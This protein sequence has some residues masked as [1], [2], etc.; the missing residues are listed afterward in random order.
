MFLKIER[1]LEITRRK[2]PR[3]ADRPEG[4]AQELLGNAVSRHH[5][6]GRIA[7]GDIAVSRSQI[8]NAIRP[9]DVEWRFRMQLCPS[10][11]SRHQ[12]MTGKSVRRCHAERLQV[13]ITLDR[14]NSNRKR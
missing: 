14:G 11:Q 3:T 10:G 8:E 2:K 13:A 6:A 9:D 4:V 12:P 1:A 5:A 7:N